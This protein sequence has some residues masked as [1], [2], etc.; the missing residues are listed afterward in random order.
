MKLRKSVA[1]AMVV[2]GLM[3]SLA[4]C[5]G[6]PDQTLV[7]SADYPSYETLAAATSE[8]EL[9]IEGEYISSAVELLYPEI[10]KG[11]DEV[12]NPQLGIELS[13]EDLKSMAIVTT[14]SEVRVTNVFKGGAAVGDIIKVSQ[15]GGEI[16]DV[17]VA[18]DSTTLLSTIRDSKVLLLLNEQPGFFDLINPVQGLYT[19]EGERFV[20]IGSRDLDTI[21]VDE[22]RE[23][24]KDEG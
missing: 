9:V 13:E 10:A 23:A 16:D 17:V 20:Q 14:V 7:G 5:S 15:L 3:V 12:S 2:S 11:G 19:V 8:A 1:A 21:S 6:A 4:A 22:I 18:N 24:I